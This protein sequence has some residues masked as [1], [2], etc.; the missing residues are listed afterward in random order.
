MF[1]A[2]EGMSEGAL[3]VKNPIRTNKN[4]VKGGNVI[5]VCNGCCLKIR[6]L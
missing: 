1:P 2:I 3:E 5:E 6:C 4:P